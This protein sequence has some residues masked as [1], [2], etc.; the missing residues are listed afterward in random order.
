LFGT[1]LIDDQT[2]FTVGYGDFVVPLR[3][4]ELIVGILWI[5][6]SALLNGLLVANFTSVI[7]KQD[8]VNVRFR[9]ATDTLNRYM[10]I[11]ALP[12]KLKERV[13]LYN[14]FLYNNSFGIPDKTLRDALP[15]EAQELILK[16]EAKVGGSV[17]CTSRNKTYPPLYVFGQ[18]YN[19]TLR[20]PSVV[21]LL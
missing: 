13:R 21:T 5:L 4:R 17:T 20:F 16:T 9:Q 6:S 1:L 10:D 18:G 3:S 7:A 14:A 19:S 11:R 12:D 2:L 8:I 15:R